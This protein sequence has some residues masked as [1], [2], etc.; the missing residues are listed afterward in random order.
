M[1]TSYSRK[2]RLIDVRLEWYVK[3]EE[4]ILT[5]QAIQSEIV[6]LQGQIWLK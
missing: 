4:A 5:G 1:A 6:L 2:P 3:A